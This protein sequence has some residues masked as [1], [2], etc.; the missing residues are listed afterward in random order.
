MASTEDNPPSGVAQSVLTLTQFELLW[1]DLKRAVYTRHP[2]DIAE[3]KQFCEEEWSKIPPE[4]CAGLICNYGK[5]L[6]EV[7]AAR[8]STSY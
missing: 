5:H 7:I 2:K 8:G 1:H 6:V 3:L 4:H